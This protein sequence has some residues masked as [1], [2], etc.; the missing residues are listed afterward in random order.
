MNNTVTQSAVPYCSLL[1]TVCTTS[2]SPVGVQSDLTSS[3]QLTFSTEDTWGGL[4]P[5]AAPQLHSDEVYIFSA[6]TVL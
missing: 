3:S 6:V 5:A 4:T 1:F 2:P